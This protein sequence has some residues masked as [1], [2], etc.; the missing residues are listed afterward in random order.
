MEEL[1]VSKRTETS[2]TTNNN[3][4]VRQGGKIKQKIT[5]KTTTTTTN[6]T[7]RGQISGKQEIVKTVT[8]TLTESSGARRLSRYMIPN[9]NI[10]IDKNIIKA[11]TNNIAV[12]NQEE[13]VDNYNDSL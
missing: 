8:N 9:V 4:N 2:T 1:V 7:G 13:I 11:N 10:N 5:A 3:Q 6:Q 12:N